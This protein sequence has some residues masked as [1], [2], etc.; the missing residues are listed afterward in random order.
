MALLTA[1]LLSLLLFIG[2]TFVAQLKILSKK[3]LVRTKVS[4]KKTLGKNLS[5][6]DT[7][8]LQRAFGKSLNRERERNDLNMPF[9]STHELP[10]D[11]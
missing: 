10:T 5:H 6:L 4:E 11:G 7:F 1:T 8:A 3:T 9:S 2:G